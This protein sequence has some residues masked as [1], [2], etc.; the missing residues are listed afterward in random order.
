MKETGKKDARAETVGGY[1]ASVPRD[2]RAALVKKLVRARIA[3]NE[4]KRYLHSRR[5]GAWS[6][7][8]PRQL[9]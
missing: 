9:D 2:A 7:A 4:A 1:L 5:W 8:R 6:K 3:E